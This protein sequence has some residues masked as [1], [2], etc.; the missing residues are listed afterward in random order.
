MHLRA[1]VQRYRWQVQLQ[2]GRV[3]HDNS[4]HTDPVQAVNQSFYLR[5]L[6]VI[7]NRVQRDKHPAIKP[8][9]IAYGLLYVLQTVPYRF[10][11]PESRTTD[12]H[13][14]RT[15]ID[16]GNRHINILCRGK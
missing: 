4:I 14:I 15:V 2:Y 12:I 10:P 6:L 7:K 1:G 5:Q 16:S 13:G 9:C 8:M 3:L 11:G